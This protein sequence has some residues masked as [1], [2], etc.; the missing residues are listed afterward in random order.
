MKKSKS[1]P[2]AKLPVKE[3]SIYSLK[4]FNLI[5]PGVVYPVLLIIVFA[6]SYTHIFDQKIDLNGDNVNYYLL[7]KALSSGK[8]YVRLNHIDEPPA[9]HFP[10]GYP[11]II[12]SVM[13]LFSKDITVIK[14]TN[15]ILLLA[16]VLLLFIL[17]GKI[18]V[19]NDLAFVVSSFVVLNTHILRSA[20]IMMSEVPFLFF[21]ILSFY[22]F[23]HLDL[24]LNP[25][26]N[27]LFY[28]FLICLSFSYYIRTTGIALFGGIALYLLLKKRWTYIVSI[29]SGFVL[30]A[31]PWFLR[32]QALGGNP[33]LQQLLKVNPYRP[34]LG[35]MGVSDLITRFL[36]NLT[37]YITKEIPNGVLPF[38]SA[39]Y[40]SSTTIANWAIGIGIII[41]I[42]YGIYKTRSKYRLLI[43][44]YLTGTFGILLLW[45]DVWFGVRFMLP[46]IPFLILVFIISLHQIL[47]QV[48]S[49]FNITW[50]PSPLAFLII[51][52]LFISEIKELRVQA[53]NTYPPNWQNYFKVAVWMRE[54]T[55]ENV[56]ISCRKPGM[57]YLFSGRRTVYYT[58]TFDD[59]KMLDNFI[60]QGV[61]YVVLEQLGYGSTYR[62]LYPAIVKHSENFPV[63][64]HYKNPD[65][66]LLAFKP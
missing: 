8:G 29:L 22:I 23:T 61:D 44:C 38:I 46:I 17:I 54:N 41:L 4:K 19:D 48:I 32:G 39:D 24:K 7:G 45:P 3:D 21:S 31:L 10:P 35:A 58:N 63:I 16:L 34:E 53:Q 52:V 62:Y 57:F 33:Y 42:G 65:T 28:L 49:R 64:L 11:A 50:K 51:L 13:T 37:R 9:S 30:L 2:K 14:I 56:V 60:K 15:G 66:Y 26:R 55:K 20:T 40:N 1:S 5:K 47:K 27:P 25:F 18:S 43:M 36:N 59:L 6:F 12:A